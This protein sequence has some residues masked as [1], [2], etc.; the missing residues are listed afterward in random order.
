MFSNCDYDGRTVAGIGRVCYVDAD[1]EGFDGAY[2]VIGDD[3]IAWRVF[4]WEVEPT[5]DTEWDGIMVRTGNLVCVMIGDDHPH[6]FHPSE[7]EEI[8]RLEYCGECGQMGCCH[9]GLERVE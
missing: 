4:G 6:L 1:P 8:D 9:D 7:I 3:G 2:R 5:E